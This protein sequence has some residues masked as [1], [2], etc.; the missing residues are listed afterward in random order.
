MR[1]EPV[2]QGAFI[3][4]GQTSSLSTEL[5]SWSQPKAWDVAVHRS[6]DLGSQSYYVISAAKQC[7]A[8]T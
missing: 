1:T 7:C 2:A 3:W 5:S 6:T 4:G 8:A